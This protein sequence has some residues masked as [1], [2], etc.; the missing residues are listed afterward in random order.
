MQIKLVP[1][2]DGKKVQLPP[3]EGIAILNIPSIYGG[4]N[5]WGESEKK[6]KGT[7]GRDS[8]KD[9]N[10]A[11]QGIFFDNGQVQEAPY[12]FHNAL[13]LSQIFDCEGN[14]DLAAN[15]LEFF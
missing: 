11:V 9:L 13:I 4:A 8:S 10:S 3:L 1:V 5:I 15:C 2:W 14:I 7:S 6:K 12:K